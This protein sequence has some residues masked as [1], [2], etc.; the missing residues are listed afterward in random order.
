MEH[1]EWLLNH[2]EFPVSNDTTTELSGEY[3]NERMEI[4]LRYYHSDNEKE[5]KWA[6]NRLMP[7]ICG[8]IK[9]LLTRYHITDSLLYEDMLHDGYGYVLNQ[10]FKEYEKVM[11]SMKLT[12][13]AK[14]NTIHAYSRAFGKYINR[15]SEHYSYEIGVVK[16]ALDKFENVYNIPEPTLAEIA[17]ECGVGWSEQKVEII[18]E[19]IANLNMATLDE[20]LEVPDTY[21]DPQRVVEKKALMQDLYD[22][23]D[24]LSPDRKE[25]FQM[26]YGLH[27]DYIEQFLSVTKIARIKDIS[28]NKAKSLLEKA[29]KDIGRDRKL[30]SYFVDNGRVARRTVDKI[31]KSKA[32][33]QFFDNLTN[34]D[35][36]IE[37]RI[38]QDEDNLPDISSILG[39]D[40]DDNNN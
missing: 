39:I 25:I 30:S 10:I 34:E 27:P 15:V 35:D 12:T 7:E 32:T 29:K 16:K 4:V 33:K 1:H 37:G 23:I 38:P 21:E 40:N 3:L 9:S 6:S 28:F 31:T 14:R 26:A 13:F 17:A 19:I 24:R 36:V 2:P 5:K 18:L 22:A 11:N 8:Y 20:A